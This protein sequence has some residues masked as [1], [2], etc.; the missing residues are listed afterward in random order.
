MYIIYTLQD[1][2]RLTRHFSGAP[3]L[4]R[5]EQLGLTGVF[6]GLIAT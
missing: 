3:C 4:E 6:K 1:Q 2:S 5:E